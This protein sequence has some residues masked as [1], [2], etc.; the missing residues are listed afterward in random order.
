MRGA[1]L[2][3]TITTTYTTNRTVTGVALY[4]HGRNAPST[5]LEE[6]RR[7]Q[8][9]APRPGLLRVG[10]LEGT[11]GREKLCVG[12]HGNSRLVVS[13]HCASPPAPIVLESILPQPAIHPHHA[14]RSSAAPAS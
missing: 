6:K 8:A 7:L 1:P 10:R 5:H 13:G 12:V 3:S 11:E 14:P 2:P 9:A 4:H